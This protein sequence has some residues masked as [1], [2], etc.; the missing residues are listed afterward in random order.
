M[1]VWEA[2]Q[3]TMGEMAEAAEAAVQQPAQV[4]LVIRHLLHPPKVMMVV[5][6]TARPHQIT[7]RLVAVDT[8]QLVD[9]VLIQRGAMAETGQVLQSLA[10]RLQGRGAEQ[11][12]L[13]AAEQHLTAARGDAEI[14]PRAA[15]EQ[16][17][18]S[19][20]DRVEVGEPEL[21]QLVVTVDQE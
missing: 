9:T 8:M 7:E 19:I 17:V 16:R 4:V 5:M 13:I 18:Q 6:G 21:L 14:L 3:T 15:A 20:Q 11:G 2:G 12:E 1:G 10:L